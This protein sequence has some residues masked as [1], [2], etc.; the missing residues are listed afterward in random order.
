MKRSS[1]EIHIRP[2]SL[3]RFLRRNCTTSFQRPISED[4]EVKDT[5]VKDEGHESHRSSF[6]SL[7]RRRSLTWQGYYMS[8]KA[9]V[10]QQ[11]EKEG[12]TAVNNYSSVVSKQIFEQA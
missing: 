12:M 1:T 10:Q 3:G 2:S 6:T 9:K 5:E 8:K 11:L 4:A 7:P